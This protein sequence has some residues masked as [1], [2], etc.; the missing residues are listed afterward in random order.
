MVCLRCKHVNPESALF[1]NRCGGSM[2]GHAVEE[3]TI[4]APRPL[5]LPTGV[6]GTSIPLQD[7]LFDSDV[8]A[9][10]ALTLAGFDVQND[11]TRTTSVEGVGEVIRVYGVLGNAFTDD[12]EV[13]DTTVPTAHLNFSPTVALELGKL[14]ERMLNTIERRLGDPDN[15][16]VRRKLLDGRV[17]YTPMNGSLASALE[18][19]LGRCGLHLPWSVNGSDVAFGNTCAKALR[20]YGFVVYYGRLG[21][22]HTRG[23]G[24]TFVSARMASVPFGVDGTHSWV[25]P[26][27]DA[28]L[29]ED[30]GL[31][32]EAIARA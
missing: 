20:P 5:R 23:S 6:R 4:A 12:E 32:V 31:L 3:S 28:V 26:I 15:D 22:M 10:A 14:R 13:T 27:H 25:P 1:C 11:L 9:R 17:K 2:A 16:R 8:E 21:L 29:D 18:A 19:D 7:S 24:P 30:V